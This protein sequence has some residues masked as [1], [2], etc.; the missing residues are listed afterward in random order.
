PTGRKG[1]V[2]VG[3]RDQ[4]RVAFFCMEYGLS[5]RFPIYSGGLAVLA[6][7]ILKTARDLDLPLVGIGSLRRQGHPR[8]RRDEHGWPHD[9]VARDT[10]DCCTAAGVRV[11]VASRGQ[12]LH[13]RVCEPEAFENAPLYLLD[14]GAPDGP[15]GW[16]TGRVY[17]GHG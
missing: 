14:A 5:S 2:V 16:I 10:P 7:D 1:E 13:L 3:R 12:T 17:D 8:Q 11:E 6:G 4:P 15:R 9:A